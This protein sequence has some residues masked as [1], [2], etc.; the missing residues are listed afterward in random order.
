MLKACWQIVCHYDTCVHT[1]VAGSS[2]LRAAQNILFGACV[3][4]VFVRT[5]LLCLHSSMLRMSKSASDCRKHW[6]GDADKAIE[7]QTYLWFCQPSAAINHSKGF[8]SLLEVPHTACST[9]TYRTCGNTYC[10]MHCK[11]SQNFCLL[12]LPMICC[13]GVEHALL[14]SIRSAV[15][16]QSMTFRRWKTGSSCNLNLMPFKDLQSCD[17]FWCGGLSQLCKPRQAKPV[18]QNAGE[19]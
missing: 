9:A 1:C 10:F 18:C 14:W 15:L 11:R 2:D 4:S 5:L 19:D 16:R 17:W 3:D 7:T 8:P 12:L 6:N 13:C